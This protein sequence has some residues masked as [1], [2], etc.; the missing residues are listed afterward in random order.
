MTP[1]CQTTA[2]QNEAMETSTEG[3]KRYIFF[4]SSRAYTVETLFADFGKFGLLDCIYPAEI[5]TGEKR[6]GFAKY[7]ESKAALAALQAVELRK[8]HYKAGREPTLNKFERADPTFRRDMICPGCGAQIELKTRKF[9]RL[10]CR[11]Q[12]TRVKGV[13]IVNPTEQM[14]PMNHVNPMNQVNHEMKPSAENQR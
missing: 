13:A 8:Y 5:R 14:N 12:M 4:I 3:E 11:Q 2:E 1:E 10:I 9:H 6:F 7:L